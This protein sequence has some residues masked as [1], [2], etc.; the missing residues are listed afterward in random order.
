MA[1]GGGGPDV[2]MRALSAW[3][4]SV[5]EAAKGM[6]EQQWQEGAPKGAAGPGTAE[7]GSR[8]G[9]RGGA[10]SLAQP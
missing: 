4:A 3:P 10:R 1:G 9:A 2:L 8:Q 5:S 6:E 7:L